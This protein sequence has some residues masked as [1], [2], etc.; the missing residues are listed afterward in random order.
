MI[1]GFGGSV[2]TEGAVY[3]AVKKILEIFFT[4]PI[5]APTVG[6]NGACSV[7]MLCPGR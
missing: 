3:G 7:T 2:S 5:T 6:R 1:T 4:V